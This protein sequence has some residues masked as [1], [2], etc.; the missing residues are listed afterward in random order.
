MIDIHAHIL[1]SIDDGPETIEESIELCK[2]AANDGIKTIVATPH[3]KDGVYETKSVEILKAVDTLN[4]QL[5]EN[6]IDVK[7]LPGAE[8]HISEGLVESI[9]NGDVLTINNGGKFILFELPFVFIPPG[10]DKFIFNLKSNGIVPIIAHAERITSFQRK[11]ELVDQ[12]VKIGARVQINAHCLTKRAIPGER[13]FAERLLKNR[14]VHFIASDV[15]SL[16]G[17]PP[18][19]SKAL[20]NATRIIGE[21]GARALVYRNP[22]LIINGLDIY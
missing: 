20:K 14:L 16:N 13:K 22:E 11:P 6:R 10:T 2:V 17:R 15:H 12:L 21:E 5:K 19:L 3:S 18:I 4:S 1:P 7:I 8:I 9:K